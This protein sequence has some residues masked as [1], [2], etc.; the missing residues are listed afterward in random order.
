M[1]L[2]RVYIGKDGEPLMEEIASLKAEGGKVLVKTLFGEE[3]E[4]D[5]AISEIDF[6]SSRVVLEKT[7]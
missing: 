5:A 1:C 3:R 7:G 2:A 6:M 4:L